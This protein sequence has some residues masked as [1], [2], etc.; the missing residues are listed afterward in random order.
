MKISI[1]PSRLR[2]R[3]S[4]K[5]IMRLSE[6]KELTDLIDFDNGTIL[7][8]SL[9]VKDVEKPE[10]WFSDQHIIFCFPETKMLTWKNTSLKGMDNHPTEEGQM[11][12]VI[13]K[14]F[15]AK[16]HPKSDN[17]KQVPPINPLLIDLVD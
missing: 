16:D 10:V 12:V 1:K 5:E 3:L 17:D 4:A 2:L 8:I 14:S 7:K 15:G 9:R 11:R 13:E 6:Q